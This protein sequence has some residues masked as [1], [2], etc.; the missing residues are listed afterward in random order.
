MRHF[1]QSSHFQR[2]PKGLL[3]LGLSFLLCSGPAL[4]HVSAAQLPLQQ[5]ITM[6]VQAETVRTV[7]TSLEKQAGVRFFYSKQLIGANRRVSMVAL[8]K[9]LAEVLHELLDPLQINFE[10]VEDGIVLTPAAAVANG[11]VSGRVVDEGGNGLPGVTVLVEGTTIGN[12]T[13]ADGSFSLQNL[14]AGPHT[15]VISFIGYGTVRQPFNVVDGQDTNLSSITMAESATQLSEAVVVGYGTA[16]RQDVTGSIT[17]VSSR[18]FVKG[19][20]TSPEQLVQ[21]KIAGVQITAAGGAPGEVSTIRIRGGSSLNAS[22][23]PLIVI[24]GVPVDNSGINGAGSALALVNPNDIETFTVLKDASATAIYGSRASNGVILITT[25]K[26]TEGEKIR[27]NVNSQ[28]S[29]SENYGQVDVLSGDQYRDLVNRAIAEG[30]M[31][32]ARAAF[33]GTANTNWQKEIYQTAWTTDNSVSVTGSAKHMPYRVS[34]GYLDQDGT[35][36]TGNLKR[37]TASVGLSPRLFDNHLRIDINAKGTWADYRFADQGAIGGAVRFDP[38]QPVYSGNSKFDGYYEWTDPA[39]P[40]GNTPYSL[41]DRNPVGLLNSKRDRS[42][43]LRSIGNVQFDYKLHF[44]PDLHVNLNLG[45]DRS[46]SS[47]TVFIPATSA[48]AFTAQGLSSNYRQEKDNKLLEFYLNYTKQI[49]DHRL[50]ALAGYSYQDFYTYSP[51]YFSRTA[52]G[53]LLDPTAQAQNPGKTQYTLLSFYGRVNYSFKDKFLATLTSRNDA[54]SRFSPETRWG[55]FP[56]ASVAWRLKQEDFLA[57][58]SVVSELKLR[59]SYGITGQ[60]DIAGVAGDYPYLARYTL[61][62][63]SVA[64][65]FG[66]D[67]I[68]TLRAAAYDRKLKWEETATYDVGIDFGFFENRLNGSLDVYLRKTN[69][70]LAVTP[71]STGSNFTPTLLTNIGNLENRGIELNLNY[72]ILRNSKLNWSVNF[73]AT[74]NRNKITKLL[75]VEDPTYL[76]TQVGDIGNFRLVQVN[77]VGYAANSFFLY[78]QQ[79]ENGK[80]VEGKYVD[81]NGDGQINERD[82]VRSE[83]TAPKLILGFSSNL[84]YGKASLAFTLR[85]NLGNSVYNNVDADRGHYA[86]VNTGLNFENNTVPDIYATQFLNTQ[87]QSDYYLYNASFLR[88]Q[89]VTLG[90]DFGSLVRA[91]STLRLTLAAQNL[92]VATFYHGID[93]ERANGIDN[94]FYPLPRT[95]TLGLNL[96]F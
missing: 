86:A 64:Q 94:N 43:V 81:Q 26:G 58:S 40:T 75:Q 34:L 20:V 83:S 60:Q 30:K 69:D 46:R 41:A 8:N 19:Q 88:L 52:A 16:R 35:L 61:G 90:Y 45:Y 39:D 59:G 54:S 15:L 2:P 87:W 24:D 72:N 96:G 79:Y 62:A 55:W 28:V 50:E 25:K 80:P 73:N 7:L 85:S 27:V 3:T 82:R 21:G 37:N 56:A 4:A 49:G 53:T 92:V 44:L 57:S 66:N 31:P 95:V 12:A 91:G 22:N 78:Q 33:L 17:T 42:T 51:F 11:S 70:L 93:P 63:S 89:N 84:N 76:G 74:A 71:I 18:D 6:Q 32:A 13:N 23:D 10:A 68:R 38:T 36:K 47:G 65:I 29:R 5:P 67:T 48:V 77:S 1:L 9:P 14:P